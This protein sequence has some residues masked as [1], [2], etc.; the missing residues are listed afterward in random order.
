[1]LLGE[2]RDLCT[3]EIFAD[4]LRSLPHPGFNPDGKDDYLLVGKIT[5]YS[6]PFVEKFTAGA[7][8]RYTA[9]EAGYVINRHTQSNASSPTQVEGILVP[10]H[11]GYYT[12]THARTAG[13][14]HGAAGSFTHQ[15][16]LASTIDLAL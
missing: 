15:R 9:Q 16:L 2:E 7:G 4:Y 8:A 10:D 5:A 11:Q 3:D 14:H 6:P 1:L 12:L 13:R